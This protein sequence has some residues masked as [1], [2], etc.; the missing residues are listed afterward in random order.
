MDKVSSLNLNDFSLVNGGPFY[1]LLMRSHLVETQSSHAFRRAIL[2]V[3][4]AL[5][6]LFG[7]SALQGVA[8][9]SNVKIP[10][11]FDFAV[12]VRFLISGPL[13]IIA[14]AVIDPRVRVIVKHFISSGIVKDEDLQGFESAVKDVSKLRDFAP[15][16]VI[17]LAIIVIFSLTGIKLE[18]LSGGISTWYSLTSDSGQKLSLAGW[19]FVAVSRPLFQFF[20][21]RWLWKLCIWYWFLWRV[22]RLN[23]RLTPTHPDLVGG[24]GFLGSGQAQFGIIVL[25]LSIV[26]SAALGEKIIFGGEKL[27]LFKVTI[28]AWVLLQLVLFLGGLL[29][30]TPQ[31][32]R[33][34]R[35]G[36]LDYGALATGYTQSFENKWVRGKATEGESILG[37][38]DI[39]SLADLANSFQVVRKMGA[40]PFS[41][42]NVIFII[43]ASV[44][45]MLPLLLTVVPVEK[46]LLTVL[47]LLF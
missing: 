8:F 42:D 24:L 38:S 10:F 27:A 32:V 34:K 4:I 26:V 33:V 14:E 28:I 36:L 44:I 15:V 35:K 12:M 29:V 40:F 2:F 22:S 5:L 39:Q 11:A 30:F 1:R 43:G 45:P 46:I 37:S 20:M 21:L 18:S 41:R 3:L 47:K 31:L 6:P 17:L 13:L 19:W 16:E 9:E 23:L 7:L 25:S